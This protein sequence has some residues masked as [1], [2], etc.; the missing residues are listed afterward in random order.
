MNQGKQQVSHRGVVSKALSESKCIFLN[1]TIPTKLFFL[2]RSTCSRYNWASPVGKLYM[3]LFS[4][5]PYLHGKLF[6]FLVQDTEMQYAMWN[7]IWMWFSISI[8]PESFVCLPGSQDN[9]PSS[10]C[11]TRLKV[12]CPCKFI[13]YVQN[14]MWTPEPFFS[15]QGSLPHSS[16]VPMHLVSNAWL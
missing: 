9:Q 5:L 4:P 15:H 10:G 6:V 13:S 11:T 7:E 8:D 16:M 3:S 1:S 2:C 14:L 12:C